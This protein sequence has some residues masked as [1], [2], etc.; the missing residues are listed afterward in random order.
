MMEREGRKQTREAEPVA[1]DTEDI[2]QI[3][4]MLTK[5]N[6]MVV[7]ANLFGC[8]NLALICCVLGLVDTRGGATKKTTNYAGDVTNNRA[9][10]VVT[11]NITITFDVDDAAFD[12]DDTSDAYSSS[13]LLGA[14]GFGNNPCIDSTGQAPL[15]APSVHDR[16]QL[17]EAL[18]AELRRRVGSG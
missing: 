9:G 3:K 18:E 6:S 2:A 15:R 10:D 8:V 14:R 5:Q 4:R 11:N 12:D 1:D 17:E 13:F 7:G 16:S